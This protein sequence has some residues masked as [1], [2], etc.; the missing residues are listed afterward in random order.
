MPWTSLCKK[1]HLSHPLGHFLNL[2]DVHGGGHVAFRIRSEA[3]MTL[4]GS[5]RKAVGARLVMKT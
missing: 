4:L 5:V 3:V 1:S 2:L